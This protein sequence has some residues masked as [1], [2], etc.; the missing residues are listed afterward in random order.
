MQGRVNFTTHACLDIKEIG[1][2]T[3]ELISL[4]EVKKKLE[5]T[6]KLKSAKLKRSASSSNSYSSPGSKLTN[7]KLE[8]ERDLY[9]VSQKCKEFKIID[10]LLYF[11]YISQYMNK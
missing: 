8:H 7:L 10:R 6:L 2:K 5:K 4:D 11:H 3:G 1:Q 9:L